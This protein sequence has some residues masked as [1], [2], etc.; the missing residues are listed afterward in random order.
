MDSKVKVPDP[1]ILGLMVSE[2]ESKETS[3]KKEKQAQK[4]NQSPIK[5]LQHFITK[6]AQDIKKNPRHHALL[7]CT[8]IPWILHYSCWR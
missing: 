1:L 6:Y 2:E 7:A 8:L 3:D 5:Q 4:A